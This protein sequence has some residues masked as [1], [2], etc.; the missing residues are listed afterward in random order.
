VDG[1]T[2]VILSDCPEGR[3]MKRKWQLIGAMLLALVVTGG[4][5][6]FTYLSATATMGVTVAG[7]EI[8]TAEP[9]A[10]QPDWNS[11]LTPPEDP[12]L[13]GEVPTGDLFDITPSAEYSGDLAVKVYLTNSGALAKAYQY[14]NM[15]LYL[16]GSVEAG[17]TPNYQVLT[18]E[19]GWVT[20]NLKDYAPGTYTLSVTGGD[21]SLVSR[22]TSEWEEGWTV[23]PELYCH[24]VQRGE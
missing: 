20:F 12:P 3:I 19:N 23:T 18:L 4:G 13:M 6:A 24:I 11:I 7:A 15:N 14:I 16:A 21:Y 5:Y 8:A 1:N 9:S 2:R 17:E 22:D 10:V